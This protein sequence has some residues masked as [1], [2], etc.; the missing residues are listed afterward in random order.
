MNMPIATILAQLM[1]RL[2]SSWDIMGAV[3]DL[4]GDKKSHSQFFDSL[5]L[6]ALSFTM[7]PEH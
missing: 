2:L 4:L 1:F 3:S 6:S 5:A 7:F